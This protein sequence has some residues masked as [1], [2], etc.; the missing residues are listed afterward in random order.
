MPSLKHIIAAVFMMVTLQ[1][2]TVSTPFVYAA[3]KVQKEIQKQTDKNETTNPFA[4]TTEEKSESG[5]SVLSEYLHDL[6][7]LNQHFVILI[8]LYKCHSSDLYCEYHPGL[9]SPPPEV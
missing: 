1:W 5:G 9:V 3:D 4:N 8:R 2:L 6:N 7:L